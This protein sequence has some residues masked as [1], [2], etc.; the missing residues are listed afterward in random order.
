MD[1]DLTNNG[2]P[3]PR[4][5]WAQPQDEYSPGQVTCYTGETELAQQRYIDADIYDSA[6]KYWR[7]RVEA[8]E[9]ER[10]RMRERLSDTPALVL[11]AL[12]EIATQ[13]TLAMSDE[14]VRSVTLAQGDDPDLVAERVRAIIRAAISNTEGL[15]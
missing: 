11:D 1:D 4:E 15:Q 6:E 5:I 14:A 10:D 7:T 8:A 3:W 12:A 9:A 13:A 2:Q